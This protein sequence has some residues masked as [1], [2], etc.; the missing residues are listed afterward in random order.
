MLEPKKTNTRRYKNR[1][2]CVGANTQPTVP[3]VSM[4]RFCAD[5]F[6]TYAQVKRLARQYKVQ[7][8][9]IKSRYYVRKS[10]PN[11]NLDN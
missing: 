9:R 8:I 10:S 5:N 6:V 4:S 3:Y 2:Y 11:I 1:R 7:M